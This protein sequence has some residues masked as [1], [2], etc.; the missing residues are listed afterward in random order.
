MEGAQAVAEDE[1]AEMT[2]RG[3]LAAPDKCSIS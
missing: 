3:S 2:A 1:E